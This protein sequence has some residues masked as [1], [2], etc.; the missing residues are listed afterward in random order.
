[1]IS[2]ED[3]LLRTV[4]SWI[5]HNPNLILFKDLIFEDHFLLKDLKNLPKD[6]DIKNKFFKEYENCK[7]A[8]VEF[9]N[10]SEWISICIGSKFYSNGLD[11]YEVFSTKMTDPIGYIDKH[12]V[13]F[14]LILFQL[15]NPKILLLEKTTIPDMQLAIDKL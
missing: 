4:N 3:M 1:M 11:T 5:A 7:Q 10:G 9:D 8:K 2:V 13:N 15:K 14:E 12:E 6:D